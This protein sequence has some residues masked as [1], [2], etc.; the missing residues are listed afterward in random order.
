MRSTF[1]VLTFIWVACLHGQ[2]LEIS[3][4]DW[5]LWPDTSASW[6]DDQLNLPADVNLQELP[7]NPPTGGWTA[8][9][10]RNGINVTLPATVE[11]FFWGKLGQKPYK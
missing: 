2:V 8:L 9:N 4:D 5:H 1:L 7:V 3:D 6:Q 10:D 11:Q